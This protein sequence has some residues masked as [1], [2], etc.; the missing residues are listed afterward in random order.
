MY[1]HI[2]R[3]R[4]QI[5]RA[6]T[7]DEIDELVQNPELVYVQFSEQPEARILDALN[8]RLFARR[9]DVWLRVFGSYAEAA[10]LGFLERMQAVTQLSL[11]CLQ[12]VANLDAVAKL[13][14]LKALKLDIYQLSSLDVL[15]AIP[16]SLDWLHIGKTKSKKPDLYAIQRFGRLRTLEIYGQS[17]NI[18]AIR[19]LKQ[20]ETLALG[21]T[22]LDEVSYLALLPK[23]RSLELSNL[24]LRDMSGLAALTGL[25]Q[26]KLWNVKLPSDLA[27]I[28]GLKSL[29]GL[30][31]EAMSTVE[32][33]PA[34]SALPD[35]RSVRL[36]N[37]KTLRRLN[38]LEAAPALEQF[39]H[40]S[41]GKMNPEDY[42]P[43]LRNPSVQRVNVGFQ[44]QKKYE[45]F[46]KLALMHGKTPRSWF[47]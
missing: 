5:G 26:L 45:S 2:S 1:E 17:R 21:S 34:L 41:V 32:E 22:T 15:Y 3:D 37:I 35:L 19:Y 46:E 11:D 18:E 23:L 33:L 44:S 24:A 27:F 42:L 40:V 12:E 16:E 6:L 31:L 13:S 20:L 4:V 10:D 28:S 8:E 9:P 14:N 29:K 30:T 38:E 39:M 47:K 36:E 43:V 7:E 25:E